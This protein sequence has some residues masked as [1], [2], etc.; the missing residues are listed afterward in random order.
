M[1]SNIKLAFNG[2]NHDIPVPLKRYLYLLGKFPESIATQISIQNYY[3]VES[4][5]KQETFDSFKKY[6][7]DSS[8]P[9]INIDNMQDFYLLSQEFNI[10]KDY[11]STKVDEDSYNL[12]ILI[13]NTSI[14]KSQNERCISRHLNDIITKHE[15]ELLKIPFS[16]L[17]NIFYHLE[18]NLN[19]HQK[20]YNFIVS[21]SKSDIL[22]ALLPSLDGDKLNEKSQFESL[23]KNKER[24]GYFP[25]F[26]Q[27]FF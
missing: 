26:K 20:A 1:T 2:V 25:T 6:L 11:L 13:S 12:T 22:F 27:S 4:A 16:S 15:Q 8:E 24:F 10:L 19:D 9:E 17:F 14:D 18:R 5:I 23:A 7:I 21:N 3:N